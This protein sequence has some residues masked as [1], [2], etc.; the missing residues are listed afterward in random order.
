MERISVDAAVVGGGVVGLS[1]AYYLARGGA[2]VAL[3]ERAQLGHGASGRTG[4]GV[5]QQ[6]REVAELPFSLK[7]VAAFRELSRLLDVD[8]E[9]RQA[10][11][12]YVALTEDMMEILGGV[13]ARQEAIGF[14][15]SRLI[16]AAEVK[17]LCPAIT[18]DVLGGMYCADDGTSNAHRLM[19]GLA[20][21]AR[22][23]GARLYCSTPV[24]EV[25]CAN[26]RV[27]S[28]RAGGVQC[29]CRWLINAAGAWAREVSGMVGPDLP[30]LPLHNEIMLTEALPHFLDQFIISKDLMIYIRQAADGQVHFGDSG[31]HEV[32]FGLH[33]SH[34]VVGALSQ[35]LLTLFPGLKPMRA[36]RAWSG[37]L[38]VSPDHLPIVDLHP[39]VEG[40]IL[41]TGFSGHGF[42]L[43]PAAGKQ[44]AEYVRSGDR[45]ALPEEFAVNR[46]TPEDWERSQPGATSLS[47]QPV[48]EKAA[49]GG[50]GA[51][52]A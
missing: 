33:S 26:G 21:G 41:A 4:C 46:F 37:V 22:R 1:A 5:R 47:V 40:Y 31:P 14:H 34:Q 51:D 44:V 6:G 18:E 42:A 24:E 38:S 15:K 45:A 9:Y 11:N 19:R 20:R 13:A 43:G 7:G 28:L 16:D 50:G 3:F 52:G 25:R 48:Y 29:A 17:A 23:A 39:E 2:Q 8:I 49:E 35:K 30:I 10:G 27:E 32:T 36:L 12:I